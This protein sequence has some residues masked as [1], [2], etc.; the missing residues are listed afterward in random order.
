MKKFHYTLIELMAAM[1]IFIVMMGLLFNVFVNASTI[2]VSQSTKVSILSDASVFFTYISNDLS[3]ISLAAIPQLM[4]KDN[5]EIDPD[6]GT[7]GG[8]GT[9]SLE[10]STD[11]LKIESS[12]SSTTLIAFRSDVEYYHD[13]TYSTPY[14]YYSLEPSPP[15]TE[16]PQLF[17]I[18]RRMRKT[19]APASEPDTEAIILDGIVELDNVAQFEIKVWDDYPG[20]TELNASTFG[21][22]PACVTISMTLTTPNPNASEETKKQSLRTITK[23]IYID[24]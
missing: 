20:G 23:T 21:I 18:T 4:D 1:S 7:R 9:A 3:N 5:N 10:A 14:V 11:Q 16:D 22:K 15:T 17:H 13:D 19:E 12:G 2:V 24:R 8:T 6:F